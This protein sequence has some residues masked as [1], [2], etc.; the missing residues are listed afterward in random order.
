MLDSGKL[1]LRMG[2]E[3]DRFRSRSAMMSIVKEVAGKT[4]E[5]L[6]DLRSLRLED[7]KE[8]QVLL[9]RVEAVEEEVEALDEWVFTKFLC[10]KWCSGIWAFLTPKNCRDCALE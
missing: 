4:K 6:A 5:L 8:L 10:W 3:L 1:D 7:R 9:C 2:T